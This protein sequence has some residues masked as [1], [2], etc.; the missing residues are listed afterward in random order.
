MARTVFLLALGVAGLH[1]APAQTL[2]RPQNGQP[3]VPQALVPAQPPSPAQPPG[4]VPMAS[5]APTPQP[6][7][8]AK[9][10][11]AAQPA[12]LPGT[13]ETAKEPEQ[14]KVA[15]IYSGTGYFDA[16]LAEKLRPMLAKTFGSSNDDRN[17]VSRIM[18]SVT[19]NGKSPGAKDEG[20]SK[21]V[22]AGK[23]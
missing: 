12:V 15:R 19:G 13:N 16:G 5:S 20:P 22:E 11:A 1:Q 9:K 18:E 2:V 17:P 10:S 4:F 3:F 8:G 6:T 23:L 14:T 7:A 21:I